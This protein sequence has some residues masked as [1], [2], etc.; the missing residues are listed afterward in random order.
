M[1]LLLC[2]LAKWRAVWFC[3]NDLRENVKW[4]KSVDGCVYSKSTLP[5]KKKKKL[6]KKKA[7]VWSSS[8]EQTVQ[9]IRL[10]S[11][12]WEPSI[13]TWKPSDGRVC[14]LWPG[15]LPF[16]LTGTNFPR[17]NEGLATQLPCQ[18]QTGSFQ[19]F[20]RAFGAESSWELKHPHFT[21]G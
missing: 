7:W 11:A 15:L 13:L 12:V 6:V 17:K 3:A 16:T 21:A 1:L 2:N 14:K 4:W 5:L 18:E 19:F 9:V 8:E 10:K 20:R